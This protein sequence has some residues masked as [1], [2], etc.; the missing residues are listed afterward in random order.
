GLHL[1]GVAG[2]VGGE[3]LDRVG[4]RGAQ[5]ERRGVDGAGGR[6]VRAVRG[7]VGLVD[8][9]AAGV[10]GGQAHRGGT[11]VAAG[12]AGR[13]VAGDRGGRRGVVRGQARID[14]LG[15]DRL[16]VARVVPGPELEG[17]GAGDRDLAGVGRAGQGRVGSV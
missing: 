11:V 5:L 10:G 9:P 15:V 2:Q 1:L 14:H 12:A 3:E 13:V 16:R 7:V 8:A 4:A 17:G 6:R